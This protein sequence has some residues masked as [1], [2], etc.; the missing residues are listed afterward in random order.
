MYADDI[1]VMRGTRREVICT[2][3][4]L[5]RTIKSV[6]PHVNRDETKYFMVVIGE[7]QTQ[8]S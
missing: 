6:S 2:T 8:T 7:F 1:A 4:K 3:A 5:L